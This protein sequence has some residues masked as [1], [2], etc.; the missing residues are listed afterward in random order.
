MRTDLGAHSL[1]PDTEAKRALELLGSS[2]IPMA[3]V[4]RDRVV[5]L[6]SE[7]DAAKWLV[8]HQR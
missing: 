6:L 1:H 7:A 2:G 4:E 3:V 5:G 8:L